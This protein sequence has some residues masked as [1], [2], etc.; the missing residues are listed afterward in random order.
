M[1][2]FIQEGVGIYQASRSSVG[3]N[4]ISGQKQR[5]Q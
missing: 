1:R 3:V 4:R 5:Q 2:K